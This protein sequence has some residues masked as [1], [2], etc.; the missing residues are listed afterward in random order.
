LSIRDTLNQKPGIVAGVLGVLILVIFLFLIF[1]SGSGTA[2]TP[3]KPKA[4]VF[5]TID[6]GKTTFADGLDKTPPFDKGGKQAVRAYVFSCNGKKE[7]VYLERFSPEVKAK[8][9]QAYAANK[10]FVYD[11][12]GGGLEVKAPGDKEWVKATDPKAAA[13]MTP[14]CNGTLEI[15]NP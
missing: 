5:Y 9:E 14:K 2:S 11:V 13:I 15:V 3:V 8:R 12:P 1:S 6:D 7:V 10:P 4:D